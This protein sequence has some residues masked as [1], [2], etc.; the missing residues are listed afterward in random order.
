MTAYITML[1]CIHAL[2]FMTVAVAAMGLEQPPLIDL[3]QASDSQPVECHVRFVD[4]D[5]NAVAGVPI[6]ARMW[7]NGAGGSMVSTKDL[8]GLTT[9]A[10]GV[11]N[12]GN[13]R[14][15]FLRL[16][17]DDD[18]YT[19]GFYGPQAL[20][21]V[22][23]RFSKVGGNG[24]L[25]YGTANDPADYYVWRKEGPQPLISLSGDLRLDYKQ[26]EIHVD[27]MTGELVDVGG[28]VVISVQV[29]DNESD[30]K[31]AAD[32]RGYF[33]HAVS[34]NVI[35]GGLT[36]IDASFDTS[37]YDAIPG[38]W[39]K[40]FPTSLLEGTS[41]LSYPAGKDVGY[42]G[43]V[44]ARDGRLHGKVRLS[45]GME[46]YW[47]SEKGRLIIRVD[48]LL[49]ASGSRSLEPDAAKLTKLTLTD[50][51]KKPEA[52]PKKP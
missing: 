35:G 52:E 29:A 34:L 3:L 12:V 43:Y 2:L 50:A 1:P 7:T 42:T 11:V 36:S 37:D 33:P 28:D 18:K 16:T 5:G 48:A 9:N 44:R 24:S 40:S 21:G 46:R 4:Q 22:V 20:P 15:G 13:Q 51:R 25:R 23:L 30:R 14:G 31:V 47:R 45:V 41:S 26:G 8:A 19:H 17:V 39:P 10:S 49:N 32:H 27:L 6:K 38:V